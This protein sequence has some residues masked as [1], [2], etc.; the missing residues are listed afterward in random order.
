MDG[1]CATTE[2]LA[3]KT[4]GAAIEVHKALGPGYL[5]SL[6]HEAMKVELQRRRLSFESEYEVPIG[7]KGCRVGKG[8]LDLLVGAQLVVELKAVEKV[9]PIHRA[10]VLH[11]L[12]ATGLSLAL[13]L[14]FKKYRLKDGIHRLILT[15]KASLQPN[16]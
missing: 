4:I 13:L 7:Y 1:V 3:K 9:R 11:Y 15:V 2:R 6:Y 16:K 12:N 5:E 8:R 14:N 10:Q